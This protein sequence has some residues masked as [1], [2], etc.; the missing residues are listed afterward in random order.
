MSLVNAWINDCGKLYGIAP[1]LGSRKLDITLCTVHVVGWWLA[2]DL[3]C[4]G[5]IIITIH[6]IISMPINIQVYSGLPIN[7]PFYSGPMWLR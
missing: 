6:K 4:G 2:K 1:L 5:A 3:W 7:A